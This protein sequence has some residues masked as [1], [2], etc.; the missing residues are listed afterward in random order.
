MLQY[1]VFGVVDG[2]FLLMATLG[3]ALVSRVHK[4]LNIAH[5]ELMSV[6]ALLTW[7]LSVQAGLPF[8][9][10]AA[11]AVVVVAA[12]G[13]A[14]GRIVYE[15][16]LSRGPEILLIV[17]V[18]VVY[19]IH[20]T[21]EAIV[22]S[23]VKSFAIPKPTTWH[24]GDLH[25]TPYQVAVVVL[26]ALCFL[27]LH[28]FLSRTSAG[29]A[30]RAIS[31][32]RELAEMRGID[33]RRATRHVWLIASGLAA[34]AGI[35]LGVLGT[36]TTDIA[37]EQIL[38]ILSVAILAGLGSIYGVAIAA[39]ALGLAMDLSTM[40][41]PGGYRTTVAFLVIIIVLVFRPQGLFGRRVRVA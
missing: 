12:L 39:F 20:G 6:A 26:A 27:G 29:S 15:P 17:S 11:I 19:L 18:G 10:A 24:L 41:V 40:V 33:V 30:I 38:L 23:G 37:F 8:L 34:V 32:N 28:L 31:D 3:F 25:V 1:A 16:M 2:A 7:G 14:L 21:V 36:L 35:G 5:A 13:L 22:S 4:F 9:A